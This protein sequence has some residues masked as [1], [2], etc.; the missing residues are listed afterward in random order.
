[1]PRQPPPAVAG[2][3]VGACYHSRAAWGWD[4]EPGYADALLLVVKGGS[5]CWRQ[6]WARVV[7][8]DQTGRS[9][10]SDRIGVASG[11]AALSAVAKASWAATRAVRRRLGMSSMQA[12]AKAFVASSPFCVCIRSA[13]FIASFTNVRTNSSH[14]ARGHINGGR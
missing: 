6:C 5:F 7:Q 2:P 14:L 4:G 12:R 9:V 11:D 3:R 8:A 10:T 1:M 13:S